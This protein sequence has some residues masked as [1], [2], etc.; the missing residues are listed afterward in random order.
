MLRRPDKSLKLIGDI[1]VAAFASVMVV[2]FY[3][4]LLT[5]MAVSPHDGGVSVDLAK[6]R[7]PK[8]MRAAGREDAI[9]VAVMR[10]GKIF[11]RNDQI[12]YDQLPAHI[13]QQL[14]HGSE[15]RVYIR[16]DARARYGNVTAILS[17]IR[18]AGIIDVT[19]FVDQ[20]RS[21]L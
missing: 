16:A 18:E 8:P 17:A 3:I 10:D 11:F 12:P 19:F 9:I 15:R 1:N 4:V 7:H 20:R 2:L 5:P 6:V 14:A 21:A 13:R